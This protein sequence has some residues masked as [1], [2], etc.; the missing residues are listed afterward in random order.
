MSSQMEDSYY[1]PPCWTT[2]PLEIRHQ[3]WCWAY[4]SQEPRIVEVRTLEHN[5][6]LLPHPR[7]CPRYSP[8]P[9]PHVV[10]ICRESR[11][12]AQRIAKKAGHLIFDTVS[13][14]PKIYFD[15]DVDT[16]YVHNEKDYWIGDWGSEGILTELRNSDQGSRLRFLAIDL[17]PLTRATTPDSLHGDLLGF[18][19]VEKI[20]FVVRKVDQ[21]VLE[22]VKRLDRHLWLW[23][24]DPSRLPGRTR[25]GPYPKECE[26]VMLRAGKFETIETERNKWARRL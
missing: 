15:P 9:A 6:Y 4:I 24:Q 16:L 11:D 26:L 19:K 8:S 22:W 21:E 2:I 17:E 1:Q 23:A 3:I 20:I 18:P 12:V 13:E 5:H 25:R 10:N 14:A 7:W